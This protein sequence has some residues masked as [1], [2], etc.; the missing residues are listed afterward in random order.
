MMVYAARRIWKRV[1][2]A[3]VTFGALTMSV[4][5]QPLD[6]GVVRLAM[7]THGGGLTGRCF[8]TQFLTLLGYESTIRVDPSLA[9]VD[10]DSDALF[11]YPLAIITGEGQFSLSASERSNMRR[12]V[13]A[14]GTLLI[15]SGC[16]NALWANAMREELAMVFP[17]AD[18]E[19]LDLDHEVFSI[20][21]DVAD[22]VTTQGGQGEVWG[23]HVEGRLAVVFSPHGLNDTASAGGACCCCGGNE[24]RQAKFINA[25]LVAYALAR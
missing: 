21:F 2:V 5:G 16:S 1:L 22:L 7:V 8:S 11:D 13:Q 24:I 19:R 3:V 9:H 14:G 17:A 15:S 12:Y 23:L 10:L 4:A 6:S 25:N 20:V 18:M